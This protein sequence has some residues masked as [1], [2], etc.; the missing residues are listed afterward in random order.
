LK[1][2]HGVADVANA[3]YKLLQEETEILISQNRRNEKIIQQAFHLQQQQETLD[4][5]IKSLQ[6]EIENMQ[7][8]HERV[9]GDKSV[10]ENQLQTLQLTHQKLIG[11]HE[12]TLR[13]YKSAKVSLHEAENSFARIEKENQNLIKDH[14]ESQSWVTKVAV[15]FLKDYERYLKV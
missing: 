8:L 14:H 12:T 13:M 5:T 4:A 15:P 10:L 11:E 9:V 3:K 6:G 7:R 1:Q 2:S